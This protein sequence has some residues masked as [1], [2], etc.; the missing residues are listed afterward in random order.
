MTSEAVAPTVTIVMPTFNSRDYVTSAIDSIVSQS[1]RDWELLVVDDGSTDDTRDLVSVAAAGDPRIR[2]IAIAV[3]SG[4]RPAVPRNRGLRE[5][6]GQ[7]IAFLDSD[8]TWQASKLERQVALMEANP[9][10]EFSYVLFEMIGL[11]G[12]RTGPYPV[13]SRRPK[14]EA[15]RDLYARPVI[16]NSAVMLRRSLLS[17]VGFLDENPTLVED[18][19][20]WLR[21]AKVGPVGC[22]E[23]DPLLTYRQRQMSHSSGNLRPWLRM[24]AVLRKHA[25]SAGW[26]LFAT[27]A[28]RQTLPFALRIGRGIFRS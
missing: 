14:G 19:D 21:I 12:R 26:P 6:R 27:A 24:M 11:D 10:L 25:P 18:H 9:E 3:N 7:Y 28:V 17:R 8:D 15:F 1:F 2:L 22:V 4:N 13:A 5:A 20:F 16:S 23:G